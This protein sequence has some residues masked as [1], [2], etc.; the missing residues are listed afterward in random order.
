MDLKVCVDRNFHDAV[1]AEGIKLVGESEN[2]HQFPDVG[3]LPWSLCSLMWRRKV[4]LCL[5][6]GVKEQVL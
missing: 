3:G 6:P 5:K 4:Y 2:Y 1:A